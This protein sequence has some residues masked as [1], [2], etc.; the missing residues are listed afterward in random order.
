M[1][2][3]GKE[4]GRE[5]HHHH[6]HTHGVVDPIILSSERGIWAV[7]W[8]LLGLLVTGAIQVVVVVLSG[9]VALLADTVHNFG[10]ALTAIPLWIAFRLGRR[11]PTRVA[12][13]LEREAFLAGY[14]KAFGLGAGPCSFCRRGCAFEEG[15]R[16]PRQARP[17]MEACGIDVFATARAGGF[18]VNVVRDHCDAQHYFGLVLVE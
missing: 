3:D 8:S 12:V 18:R 5:E 16:H 2:K 15:C 7:K 17:S 13:E 11:E 14:H 1:S 10:D 9:S 4:T 6:D